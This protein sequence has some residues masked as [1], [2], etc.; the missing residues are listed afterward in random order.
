MSRLDDEVLPA[1]LLKDMID[2]PERQRETSYQEMASD[3][4]CL[5]WRRDTQSLE[6][7]LWED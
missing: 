6:A 3:S 4:S 2:R 1:S 7:S 5:R